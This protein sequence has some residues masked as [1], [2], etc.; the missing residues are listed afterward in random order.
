MLKYALVL[1]ESIEMTINFQLYNDCQVFQAYWKYV[2]LAII[3]LFC[4]VWIKKNARDAWISLEIFGIQLNKTT[5]IKT[6]VD[7][8]N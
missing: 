8:F 5:T 4:L 7:E 2:Y 6:N 1:V 3:D